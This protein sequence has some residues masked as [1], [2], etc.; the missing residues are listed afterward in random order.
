MKQKT[1]ERIYFV[2]TEEASYM[3]KTRAQARQF[4]KELGG[5]RKGVKIIQE[6]LTH[7]EVR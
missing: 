1:I 2:N 6:K 7:K 4:S 5:R 3:F